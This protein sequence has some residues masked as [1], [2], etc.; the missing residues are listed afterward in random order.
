M[1]AQ[2][3]EPGQPPQF[4]LH[5]EEDSVAVAVTDIEPG[6]VT[7]AV[8][9]TGRSCTFTVG[10]PVPLGHKFAV[11]DLAEGSDVVKYGVRVG[12]VT[13]PVST[14]DYVHVHNMRS[15]RWQTSVA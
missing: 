12:T 8:M 9:T 5:H 11:T 14:G 15:A 13:A 2:P 1:G 10:H 3:A 4:L 6:P 7:G